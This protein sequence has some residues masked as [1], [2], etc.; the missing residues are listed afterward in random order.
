MPATGRQ[1]THPLPKRRIV[2]TV[3]DRRQYADFAVGD[4]LLASIFAIARIT[5][6]NQM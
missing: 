5:A 6:I 1:T 2:A 3:R 4:L